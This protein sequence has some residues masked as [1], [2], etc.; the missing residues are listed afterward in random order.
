MRDQLRVGDDTTG[1]PLSPSSGLGLT[2][3]FFPLLQPM[4]GMFGDATIRQQGFQSSRV[5]R[6]DG[7]DPT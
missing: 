5:A 6:G 2:G 3:F 4:L 7:C 1:G